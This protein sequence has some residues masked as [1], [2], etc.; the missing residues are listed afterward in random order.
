MTIALN[1]TT[2]SAS[3]AA[4]SITG[5]TIKDIDAIPDSAQN[6]CPVIIPQTEFIT[7]I[8]PERKSFGSGGAEKIDFQYTLNYWFLFC[9]VGSGINAF[10]PYEGL[11]QK[12]DLILETILT[13]D[14][15]SGLV[16]LQLQNI[17]RIGTIQDASEN[18]YWGCSFSVRCLEYAE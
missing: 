14:T 3:I 11:I 1:P 7:D 12:L 10:A 18:M 15:V 6:L 16:D 4:L 13:N 2:V 17:G 9:E 5:V 8:Q